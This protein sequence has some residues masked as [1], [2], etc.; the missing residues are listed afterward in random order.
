M[1][2]ENPGEKNWWDKIKPFIECVGI[3]LLA[4]YTGFTIAMYFANNKA[5]NAARD[6]ANTARDYLVVSER[7]WVKIKHR[8]VKPLTFD[9]PAQNGPVAN[10][11]VEDTLENVGPT[12]AFNVTSWEDILPVDADLSLHTARARQDQ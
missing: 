8:I 4:V 6:S 12:V 3:V 7:P 11:I 2:A 1:M 5:A 9:T 10:M